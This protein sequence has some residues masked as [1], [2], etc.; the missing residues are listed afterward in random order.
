[1][2]A[3]VAEFYGNEFGIENVGLTYRFVKEFSEVNA[4]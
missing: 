2:N 1:M 4:W 3:V